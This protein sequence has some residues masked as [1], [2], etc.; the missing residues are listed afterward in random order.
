MKREIHR[1]VGQTGSKAWMAFG[2]RFD[3]ASGPSAGSI[4]EF[5]LAAIPESNPA[6][7]LGLL[8][9][10]RRIQP[11]EQITYRIGNGEP[12]KIVRI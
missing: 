9:A 5:G 8:E 6:I 4:K 12:I 10:L 1:I 11:L 3:R 2:E 7:R